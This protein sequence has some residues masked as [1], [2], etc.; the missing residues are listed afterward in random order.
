MRQH[1]GEEG[2]SEV[3][4]VILLLGLTVLAVAI[5]AVPFLSAP[6]PD[7]IPHATIVAGNRS[8]SFALVHEGGDPL[9]AGEYRIYVDAGSGLVDRTGNFTG[10]EGGVWSIGGVLNYTG[11]ADL[12]RVIVTVLTGDG[13]ETIL[14]EPAFV[15]GEAT[16]S[17]DPVEPD[18]GD[19]DDDEPEIPFID[20]VINE[21][22]FIY[23]T[24][25]SIGEGT[26][27]GS[28]NV[29]GPGA[30]IVITRGLEPEDLGGNGGI[31]VSNIYING[32]VSKDSGSASLGSEEAP[33]AIYIN[34]DLVLLGG[35]R[36]IYGKVYVNGDCDLGGVIIH[37]DVYVNG[38]VTLRRNVIS[39]VDGAHIYCTG[40]I[41]LLPGVDSSTLDHCT[42][43]TP[44][45][46]FTMP[47][48]GIPSTKPAEWYTA[49]EYDQNG[50]LT[51]NLKIFA[52]SYSSPSGATASNVVIIAS[53]GDISI[54]N[55]WSDKVT[56]IFFAPQ[57]RV[58][59]N[60]GSLEG[61][62]IARDGFFV[63]N[64]NTK[65]TFKNIDQY[66]SNPADYPF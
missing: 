62:V 51:N 65:V 41:N 18:E 16:F 6:Q 17:P 21:S 11:G 64:G 42:D 25:L 29:I 40:N 8:G 5:V 59:F 50:I 36:N 22:V 9:R 26:G 30:T 54:T 20:F 32:S 14:S 15:G 44:F 45:P 57:G 1:R 34:G 48:Q 60:G 35:N 12:T 28:V 4:G 49:K 53:D 7:E 33:G 52:N 23:G 55:G 37:D 2:V 3:I 63:I 43:Q 47:D 39:F 38:D 24:T 13:G 56:G 10:L 61:V 58:T 19:E 66:I 46:G 31:S 27:K